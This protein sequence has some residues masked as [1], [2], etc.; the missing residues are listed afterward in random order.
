MSHSP[1]STLSVSMP[2]ARTTPL[3]H[4]QN[5]GED[6]AAYPIWA[7]AQL[8]LP[9]KRTCDSLAHGGVPIVTK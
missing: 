3:E 9:L 4:L 5:T 8:W 7:A 1:P 6:D 2:L